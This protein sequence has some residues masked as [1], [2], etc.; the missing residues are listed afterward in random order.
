[1]FAWTYSKVQPLFQAM[2]PVNTFSDEPKDRVTTWF[3]PC[4]S[5]FDLGVVNLNPN[6]NLVQVN[7]RFMPAYCFLSV[8][9]TG[10]YISGFA[11]SRTY[12]NLERSL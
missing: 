5:F 8:P 6:P 2:N 11:Y 3:V 7:L 4:L 9:G 1:M 12:H 10:E